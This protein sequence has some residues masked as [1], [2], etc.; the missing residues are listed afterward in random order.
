MS[1]QVQASN[2]TTPNSLHL[3]A[4]CMGLLHCSF[5][6]LLCSRLYNYSSEVASMSDPSFATELLITLLVAL[7]IA[8]SGLIW[9]FHILKNLYYRS[10]DKPEVQM[11]SVAKR[12][13]LSPIITIIIFVVISAL[14]PVRF[15][16][17]L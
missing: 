14:F 13:I 11:T 1:E 5:I 3:S 6:V 12:T 15:A 10:K 17:E 4:W 16:M 9:L 8:F 2:H 7:Q